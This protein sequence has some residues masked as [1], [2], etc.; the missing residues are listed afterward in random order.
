MEILG[1]LTSA[2]EQLRSS[3]FI[4]G[5]MERTSG[6]L[7]IEMT[8]TMLLAMASALF[9]MRAVPYMMSAITFFMKFCICTLILSLTLQLTQQSEL[10]QAVR[11]LMRP[12]VAA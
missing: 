6:K 9:I 4:D 3:A 5:M 8:V 1:R 12:A 7:Y 11:S 10:F 2:I